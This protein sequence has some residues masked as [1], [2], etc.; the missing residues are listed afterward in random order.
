MHDYIH[1]IYYINLLVCMYVCVH[2]FVN[3]CV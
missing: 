2:M 3:V 1:Y